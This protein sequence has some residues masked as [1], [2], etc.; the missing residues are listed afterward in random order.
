[1]DERHIG[2]DFDAFLEAEGMLDE[3]EA[4][5]TK[6]VIAH[7]IAEEM[8]CAGVS[9][10]ELARRMHTSRASVTRLL[11]PDNPAVTLSTLQR[12]A[13]ALGKRL[14]VRLTS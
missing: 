13:R 12:A 11:D 4:A 6:R 8:R 9:R 2:S 3:V 5:A 14:D 10:S 7:G 1:M